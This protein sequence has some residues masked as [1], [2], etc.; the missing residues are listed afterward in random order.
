MASTT[1]L[2]NRDGSTC[3]APQDPLSVM[4]EDL[5]GKVE[6]NGLLAPEM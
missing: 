2:V 3:Q 5:R 6:E 1:D 4:L